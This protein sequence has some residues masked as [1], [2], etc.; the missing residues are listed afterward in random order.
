MAKAY[1]HTYE[2]FKGM[3]NYFYGLRDFYHLIK[4]FC[5]RVKEHTEKK[6]HEGLQAVMFSIQENFG[7]GQG[8]DNKL[9]D[10]FKKEFKES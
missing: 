9:W 1:Y 5:N 2:Y 8:G 3:D 6:E 4:S 7:G 10:Y